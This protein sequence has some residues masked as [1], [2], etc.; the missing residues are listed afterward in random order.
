MTG[1]DAP[2]SQK[3]GKRRPASLAAAVA[4]AAG[5]AAL[6][7][8]IYLGLAAQGEAWPIYVLAAA[9]AP[10]ALLTAVQA[11]QAAAGLLRRRGE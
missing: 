1:P 8:V 5:M 3:V 2:T 9:S 7:V 11:G 4:G 6:A 10:L